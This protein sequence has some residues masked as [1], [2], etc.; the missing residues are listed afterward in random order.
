MCRRVARPP[1]LR[2]RAGEGVEIVC[3]DALGEFTYC[4]QPFE[5]PQRLPKSQAS[6]DDYCCRTERAAAVITPIQLEP[7]AS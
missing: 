5:E 2:E 4:A 1:G 7:A 3:W 6:E